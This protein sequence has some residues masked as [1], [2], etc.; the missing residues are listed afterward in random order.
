[1]D[2]LGIGTKTRTLPWADCTPTQHL[3]CTSGRPGA[4]KPTLLK[5]HGPLKGPLECAIL[6]FTDAVVTQEL[7]DCSPWPSHGSD[8]LHGLSHLNPMVLSPL[9]GG[10]KGATDRLRNLPWVTPEPGVTPG[11][12]DMEVIHL[13]L[14]VCVC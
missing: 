3:A 8:P 12:S 13:L 11:Q 4:L 1:M 9:Y 6:V 2:P 14:L 7:T 5:V 10:G